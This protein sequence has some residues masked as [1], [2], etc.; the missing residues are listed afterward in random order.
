ML[1]LSA[2]TSIQVAFDLSGRDV[3]V[4]R[5]LR[6]Y[7][8]TCYIRPFEKISRSQEQVIIVGCTSRATAYLNTDL[9]RGT[10]VELSEPAPIPLHVF[11]TYCPLPYNP[12]SWNLA[13]ND[14]RVPDTES[15]HSL[16][17]GVERTGIPLFRQGFLTHFRRNV[18]TL[19][20]ESSMVSNLPQHSR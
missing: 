19:I 18:R 9:R 15:G 12:L 8:K 3:D 2:Y 5:R 11:T 16:R 10:Y 13:S 1:P 6:C 4:S 20:Y 14:T 7:T 17:K